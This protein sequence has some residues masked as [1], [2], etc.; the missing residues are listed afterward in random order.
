MRHRVETWGAWVRLDD[1]PALVALDRAG[2]RALGIDLDRAP[3]DGP[4]EAH[5]AVTSQCGVGCEGCYLDARP[6]GAHVPRDVLEK[7]LDDLAARGVFTVAFGGGEPILRDDLGELAECARARGLTAVLTTSGIGMTKAK[8]D[9]LRAFA[10]VNVS[11]DGEGDVYR[12]V[13]AFPGASA[14]ERAM[15][16][17][18]DAGVPFGVNVV[19]TKQSFPSLDATLARARE[20]GAREAQLLRYKPA[21]RAAKLDYVDKRLSREQVAALG[22]TLRELSCK[23]QPFG[24]RIRIDCAMVALLADA[25]YDRADDL[26]RL[27]VFGCEAGAKLAAVRADGRVAPCSFLEPSAQAAPHGTTAPCD[28]CALARVCRGGCKAVARFLVG[29][30]APDPECPRV[31]RAEAARG[32]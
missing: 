16:L 31:V 7:T 10:Q 27:G 17:L 1:P 18:R 22:E 6:D 11:Y 26:E 3:H 5:V 32:A 12:A 23:L 8:A 13:R 28:T 9:S 4:L 2:A 30:D 15:T 21:G 20:L 29:H 14:A 19:L 25:L 24:F